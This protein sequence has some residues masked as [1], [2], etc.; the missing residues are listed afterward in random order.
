MG[1]LFDYNHPIL[2]FMARLADLFA[3]NAMTLVGCLPIITIGA[4][5]TAGHYTALKL[6]RGEG[7]VFQ[8]F[9]QS[10]KENFKQSTIIW[11]LFLCFFAIEYLAFITLTSGTIE[12]GQMMQGWV[13]ATT[14]LGVCVMLWVFPLQS[15]FINPIGK[16]LRLA[17]V[18]TFKYLYLTIPMLALFVLPF[19]VTSKLFPII[20]LCGFS[21]PIYLS[22]I[23]YNR[24]FRKLE[25]QV[26]KSLGGND[27]ENI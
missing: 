18:M 2:R 16:T 1:K 17:F 25:E 11:I 21:V 6:H 24:S 5:I 13:I 3:I 26:L 22:A 20:F 15:K 14:V 19:F 4:S 10:F 12:T 7:Y 8:N 23:L 9:W 27:N